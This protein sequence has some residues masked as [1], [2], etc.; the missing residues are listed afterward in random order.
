MKAYSLQILMACGFLGE[1]ILEKKIT[2]WAIYF[3]S[4]IIILAVVNFYTEFNDA[5]L[6]GSE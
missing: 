1:L 6:G 2:G 5:F 3:F 4:V